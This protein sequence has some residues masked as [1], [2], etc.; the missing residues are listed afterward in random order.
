MAFEFEKRL[1]YIPVDFNTLHTLD[2][3]TLSLV[4]WYYKEAI[5]KTKEALALYESADKKPMHRV[6]TWQ[7]YLNLLT[8]ELE[9]LEII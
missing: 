3:N 5:R 6:E 7:A 9:T 2:P 4:I 8:F 1:D